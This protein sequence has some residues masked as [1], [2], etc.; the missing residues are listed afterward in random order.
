[1]SFAAPLVPFAG[2]PRPLLFAHRG[3][4]CVAPEN[5][6]EAFDMASRMGVQVLE[7]DVHATRDGEVVVLHDAELQR[8]TDGTGLVRDMSYQELT[9]LDAGCRFVTPY[10][11]KPF[12]GRG[13]VVPRL[14][15]V[16][17][18]FPRLGFNIEIKAADPALVRNTLNL[19]QKV[20][21]SDSQ[22]VLAAG[23]DPVM[24]LLEAAKP[25]TALG[26]SARQAWHAVRGAYWGGVPPHLAGRALQI[27]PS[28][29]GLPLATARVIARVRALGIPVHVWTLNHPRAARKYLQ[30]GV[31]GIMSDD[32]AALSDLFTQ[33]RGA[34]AAR[35]VAS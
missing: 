23:V 6:L 10:G 30:R 27:P 29:R 33:Y 32:P 8:T 5:T 34:A 20:G 22:V 9:Q 31:D 18:A 15:D 3:A 28:H 25:G 17:R 19:L 21:L 26:M 24:D 13:V 7:M 35:S 12:A 4:S 11:A 14:E 2:L 16:L 1:M